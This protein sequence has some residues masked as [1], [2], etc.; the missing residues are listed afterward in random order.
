MLSSVVHH[1]D[2]FNFDNYKFEGCYDPMAAYAFSK[3]ANL[4]T[5]DEIERHLDLA[6]FMPR[7]SNPAPFS[8]T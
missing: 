2:E 1:L 5:A 8:R 6:T 3:T 7:A 4:W